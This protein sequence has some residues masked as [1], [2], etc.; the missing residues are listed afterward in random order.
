MADLVRWSP[1]EE[2]ARMRE[3]WSRLMSSGFAVPWLSQGP[4]F[5]PA[6]DLRETE[7]HLIVEAEVPGINP[8]DIDLVVTEDGLTLRGEVKEEKKA[9]EKGFRRLERRYGSF[10]R[11]IPFPVPVKHEEAVADYKNGVL[12]VSLPKSESA[13][14]KAT[15]LKIRNRDLQ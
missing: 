13:H 14:K 10:H 1:F 6:V 9:E 8:E 15:R 4:A 2:M 7:T 5:G 11:R 3:D 12:Q